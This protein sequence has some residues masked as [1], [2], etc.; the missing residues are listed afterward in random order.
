[1]KNDF[2]AWAR[3]NSEANKTKLSG[4]S[5]TKQAYKDVTDVNKIMSR[6]R[7]ANGVDYPLSGVGAGGTFG[8]FSNI[9]D[10]QSALEQVERAHVAFMSLPAV[11]RSK[12]HNNAA[13]FLDFC[14][15]PDNIG[16]MRNLGLLKVENGS[17]VDPVS[18]VK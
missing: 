16:E 4:V 14:N 9:T 8:D 15:N 18:N 10:Y 3:A 7:K 2:K 6:F 12:F 17:V 13:A 5:R 1:M 11:V